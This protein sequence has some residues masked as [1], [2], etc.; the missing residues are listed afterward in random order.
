MLRWWTNARKLSGYTGKEVLP[1]MVSSFGRRGR[2]AR[3]FGEV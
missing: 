2:G 3:N 1:G